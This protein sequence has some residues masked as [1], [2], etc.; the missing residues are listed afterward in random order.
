MGLL[1][2]KGFTEKYVYCLNKKEEEKVNY[3]RRSFFKILPKGDF[4]IHDEYEKK[5]T[6]E[7]K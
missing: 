2:S 4:I 3:I 1:M 6:V 7:E 5:Q